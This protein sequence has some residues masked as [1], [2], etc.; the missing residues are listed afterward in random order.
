M[1]AEEKKQIFTFK[2]LEQKMRLSFK[3]L[4]KYNFWNSSS[5]DRLIQLTCSSSLESQNL[6]YTRHTLPL[7]SQARWLLIHTIWLWE[8]ERKDP[9]L[10]FK[11]K[12]IDKGGEG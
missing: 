9:K 7:T 1:D 12:N 2:K 5:F 4:E 11:S 10:I 8:R 6:R 3:K